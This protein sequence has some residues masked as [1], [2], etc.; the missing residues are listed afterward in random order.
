M[1]DLTPNLLPFLKIVPT[2]LVEI[3]S[4]ATA[5]R[6]RTEKK[7]LYEANGVDGYWLIDP[8]A[9]K[10]MVFRLVAGRYD[11]GTRFGLRQKL[12]SRILPKL[13]VLTRSFFA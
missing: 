13:E 4:P 1:Q 10:V 7:G 9:R 11:A 3:L 5:R 12:H 2:L 6:D 8:D